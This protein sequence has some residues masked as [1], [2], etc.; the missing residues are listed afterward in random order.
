ML[1][2]LQFHLNAEQSDL[3]D[4]FSRLISLPLTPTRDPIHYARFL[5]EEC[6]Y[7]MKKEENDEEDN[8]IV[9]CFWDRF[10]RHPRVFP[11]LDYLCKRG[12]DI[13]DIFTCTSNPYLECASSVVAPSAVVDLATVLELHGHGATI[14]DANHILSA[15]GGAAWLAERPEHHKFLFNAD[16]LIAQNTEPSKQA[17]KAQIQAAVKKARATAFV[18]CF[19]GKKL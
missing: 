15:P 8:K 16:K 17:L 6:K 18:I 9:H 2:A 11:A 13:D 7:D 10:R 3:Q 19:Y 14:E 1:R 4:F 12:G 5:L